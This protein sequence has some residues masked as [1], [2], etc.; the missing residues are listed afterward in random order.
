MPIELT[1]PIFAAADFVAPT[2]DLEGPILSYF[3]IFHDTCKS[4]GY[5]T[6]VYG[7]AEPASISLVKASFIR[8]GSPNPPAGLATIR[9]P[10]MP[11]SKAAKPPSAGW[12]LV[13]ITSSIR[14]LPVEVPDQ[15]GQVPESSA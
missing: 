4:Y 3:T 13:W 11:S 6:E 5:L 1:K 12:M 2:E 7:S 8:P 15:V 14:Q 10:D 9:R